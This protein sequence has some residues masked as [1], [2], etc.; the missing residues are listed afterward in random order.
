[1]EK[2]SFQK[3]TIVFPYFL[4][5]WFGDEHRC[6][7]AELRAESPSLFV[8]LNVL[9]KTQASTTVLSG[10]GQPLEGPS[11]NCSSVGIQVSLARESCCART[12]CVS[13]MICA[14]KGSFVLP[15]SHTNTL[16]WLSHKMW[17]AVPLGTYF[18]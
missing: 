17:K 16:I 10:T 9:Q 2:L 15:F 13:V 1:M 18:T 6:I 12:V 4:W 11:A 3:E 5:C 8:G 14:S 7:L